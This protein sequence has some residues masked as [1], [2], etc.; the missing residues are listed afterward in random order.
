MAVDPLAI[1]TVT[2]LPLLALLG[3]LLFSV[4]YAFTTDR[5]LAVAAALFALMSAHQLTEVWLLA[6]GL[7]PLGNLPGEV[8]ETSV[9]LLAV[10][11]VLILARRLETER[12]RRER[13]DVVT[14]E[15]SNASHPVGGEEPTPQTGGLGLFR[16][17]LLGL[18]V[19]GQLVA[20]AYTTLPL[21]TTARLSSVIETAVRNVQVTFPVT[22]VDR[23]AVPDLPVFA[24]ATTLEDIVE[25]VLKQFVVY[26]DS[27]EP[28][29]RIDGTVHSSTVRIRIEDNGPGL[30][31]AV[32]DQLE[33]EVRE[34]ANPDLEL[35]PVHGLLEKWG[36]SITVDSGTVDLTLLSPRPEQT[37]GPNEGR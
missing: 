34:S 19:V 12:R 29:I 25:T 15:L 16:P 7:D 1:A 13:Q 22:T 4:W 24:E 36:G 5:R 11:T 18:P 21:G 3:G 9:N 32:A 17:A 35:A 28:T 8:F 20:W 37:E 33:G 14:R 27:S 31:A 30:P 6:T 26:N 10:V 2:I 23:G